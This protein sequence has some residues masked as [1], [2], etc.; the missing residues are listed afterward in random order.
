MSLLGVDIGTSSCK[1]I[2]FDT[3]G[4]RLG[5]ASAEYPEIYPKAGWVEMNPIQVWK[6][7]RSTIK[8]CVSDK[9]ADLPLALG[10]SVL[11]EAV[12]PINS[13]GKELHNSIT[14]VDRRCL[15]Q[16]RWWQERL[17]RERIFAITGMPLHTCYTLNKI[18]WIRE[19]LPEVFKNTAKFLLYEDYLIYKFLR[20]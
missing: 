10:L 19:E 16:T 18:L 1:A 3:G 9:K 17:G 12:T 13:S 14:S 6:A 7:V 20:K 4:N 2:L 5:F 8:R 11:G 15:S